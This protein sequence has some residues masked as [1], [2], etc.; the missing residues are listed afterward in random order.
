MGHGS[1]GREGV[2][3]SWGGRGIGH[4]SPALGTDFFRRSKKK[5]AKLRRGVGHKNKN[6]GPGS[7]QL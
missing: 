3:G 2:G 4:R 1:R 6:F 5:V 7:V